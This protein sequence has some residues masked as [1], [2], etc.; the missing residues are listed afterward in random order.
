MG[1]VPGHRSSGRLIISVGVLS[2]MSVLAVGGLPGLPELAVVVA[3]FVLLAGVVYAAVVLGRA[4]TG[5]SSTD[6]AE[7]VAELESRVDDLESELAARDR[8][9]NSDT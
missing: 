8:D 4:L 3:I 2:G 1:P 5:S 6:D 7:R 9:D